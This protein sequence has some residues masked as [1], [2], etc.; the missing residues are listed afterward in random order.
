M[1]FKKEIYVQPFNNEE[2]ANWMSYYEKL[3]DCD[4][5]EEIGVY[6]LKEIIKIKKSIEISKVKHG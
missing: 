2:G 5:D 6:E 1:E 4:D 3:V